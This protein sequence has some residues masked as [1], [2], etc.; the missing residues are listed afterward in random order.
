MPHGVAEAAALSLAVT[1]G[2]VPLVVA[3]FGRTSVAALP[4][5]LLAAVAV[6]PVMWLG[7]LAGTIGQVSAAA[8][9]PF[10]ALAGYPLAYLTWLAGVAARAPLAEVAAPPLA[11]AAACAAAIGVLTSRRARR[12]APAAALAAVGAILAT[13]AAPPTA[14]SPPRG[15]RVTFLDVGQG[16]ATL[17][18]HRSTTVLVDTGPPDG[19][20]VARLRRA[21]VRRLDL[22]VVT[23]AQADH[24]GGAAAVLRAMP[25]GLVLDGRDG[26][27]DAA[28]ARLAAE[29]RRRR[30]AM[31]VPDAGQ[32]LQTGGC[33]CT[34]SGRRARRPPPMSALIPISARSSPWP[35]SV[36]SACC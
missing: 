25:V 32:V 3:Y 10:T 30:V 11:V 13:A 31:A 26:V 5:N 19:P 14:A 33:G 2:T 34:S 35:A 29:A 21:G 17:L 20:I 8:A 18:Q 15:L 1:I 36:A 27:R 23:H 6:P 7:M 28:G 9:A 22:L 4:A 24:D 12:L 16:D